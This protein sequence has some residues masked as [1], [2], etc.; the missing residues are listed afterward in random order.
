MGSLLASHICLTGPQIHRSKLNT[1]QYPYDDISLKFQPLLTPLQISQRC[2]RSQGQR[3]NSIWLKWF[4]RF[5]L[6]SSDE[7]ESLYTRPQHHAVSCALGKLDR[8]TLRAY[9]DSS[10]DNFEDS[11]DALLSVYRDVSPCLPMASRY[12]STDLSVH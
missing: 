6:H 3:C 2:T 8:K 11:I 1:I 10:P 4:K 5:K 12:T 7:A 9:S